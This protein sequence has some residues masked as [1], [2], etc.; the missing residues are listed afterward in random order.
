MKELWFLGDLKGAKRSTNA[1]VVLLTITKLSFE[2]RRGCYHLFAARRN[3]S[4]E[5][6]WDM[7]KSTTALRR[8]TKISVFFLLLFFFFIWR[9]SPHCSR[10]C[11][12]TRF[13]D[14]TQ[15]RTTVGRTPLD[16]WI[17]RRRDLCL[18]THNTHNRQTSIPQ[19]GFEPA[20]P[21]SERPQI[22][23]LHGAVTGNIPLI[24]CIAVWRTILI[25]QLIN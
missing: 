6:S 20:I 17:A 7:S 22:H 11:S 18:T 5:N 13:L 14:H 1:V 21:G 2:N 24:S 9:N 23:T 3:I 25:E 16:E 4:T 15:R 19:V 8:Q 10:A 12:F